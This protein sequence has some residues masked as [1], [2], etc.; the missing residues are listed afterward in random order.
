MALQGR[1]SGREV[2]RTQFTSEL[3]RTRLAFRGPMSADT[4]LAVLGNQTVASLSEVMATLGARAS[5]RRSPAAARA[6]RRDHHPTLRRSGSA[7]ASATLPYALVQRAR[8]VLASAEGLANSAV[9]RRFGVTP[10]TVGKWRRRFR[11]AGIEG[12]HDEFR[13]GRPRTYDDEKVAAVMISRA[14][15]ET[16]DAATHWSTRAWGELRALPRA[17]YKRW[18]ALFGVK[19]HLAKTFKLSTDPFFIE[20]VRDIVGLCLSPPDHAMVLCVDEKSQIQA[21]NRTQPTLPMGL[22][23]AEGYTH[24]Y[25]RHG[26]TTLFA[27]LDI[28]TGKVFG[29]VPEAAPP[30]GVP[31]VPA[32]DRPGGTGGAGHP[33]GPGQLRDAQARQGQAVAG[34]ATPLP[35]ALH[36]HLGVLAEPGGAVVRVA[37]PAGDQAGFVPQRRRSGEQD[38][39]V[40]RRVQCLRHA[41]CLGRHCTVDP[42]QPQVRGR[43][44]VKRLA[45]PHLPDR[46]AADQS[47]AQGRPQAA[48]R[49]RRLAGDVRLCS[50]GGRVGQ[51]G[52]TWA[53][54]MPRCGRISSRPAGP[55][56]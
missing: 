53:R 4:I 1:P 24:D 27:A 30:R 51:R 35:S 5:K 2:F 29:A 3:H 6:D 41:L 10:Q 49:A 37:Q 34:G 8:M 26:T 36:A 32:P 13:P 43:T 23:Y 11:A 54:G 55:S 56:R 7:P 40:H 47:G 48:G 46:R 12:L 19:P 17:R 14:L 38:P 18:L 39:S 50:G 21:L 42:R 28:A 16:P 52:R 44:A 22:G 45:A 9:A 25:V 20:K 33:P 31:V 15:Q